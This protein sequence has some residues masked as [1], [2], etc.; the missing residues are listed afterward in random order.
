MFLTP[1]FSE[2]IIDTIFGNGKLMYNGDRQP[3]KNASL[4]HP[5]SICIDE[6]GNFYIADTFNN[7]IRKITPNGIIYTIAGMGKFGNTVMEKKAIRAELAHP[8]GVAAETVDIENKIVRVYI[9]DTVNNKIRMINKSGRIKT[10]GGSGRYGDLGNNKEAIRAEL[11]RPTEVALDEYGNVYLTDTYNNKIKVIYNPNNLPNPGPIAGASHIKNPKNEHI[12]TIAGTGTLGYSKY[13]TKAIATH[14]NHPWDM[15][16][17]NNEIYFSDKNNHIIR[18][19]DKNGIISTIAGLPCTPGY[20]GDV[21]NAN[22]EKVN[23][24][25]GLWAQGNYVYF[26]DSMNNRIR[27]IDVAANTISTV[28]GSDEFGYG[29]DGCPAINC[30]LSHP[31]DVFGD[32]N[33]NLYIADRENSRIRVVKGSSEAKSISKASESE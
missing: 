13:E 27:K 19:I 21:L 5:M 28:A 32:K 20:Y 9:A 17:V 2:E 30:M 33:G 8:M 24:P 14:L 18:K 31:A 6:I 10:I 16:I 1:G 7:R 11:A 23:S 22:K 4:Y 3:A 26:A 29:G 12:Y 15:C 25:L